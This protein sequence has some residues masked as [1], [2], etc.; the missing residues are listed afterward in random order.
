MEKITLN[1]KNFKCI[2]ILYAFNDQSDEREKGEAISLVDED[3]VWVT[4]GCKKRR[5]KLQFVWLDTPAN[6]EALK[7][8]REKTNRSHNLGKKLSR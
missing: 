4:S 2:P 3:R 6:Q 7:A 8:I 5:V 1:K